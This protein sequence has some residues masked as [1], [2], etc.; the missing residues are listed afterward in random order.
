[1]DDEVTLLRACYSN[2][3]QL[4]GLSTAY[5]QCELVELEDTDRMVVCVS[6]LVIGQSMPPCGG[7]DL[8][9]HYINLC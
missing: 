5:Q 9:I 4:S 7:E 3:E 1:M 8:G 6:D 2:F